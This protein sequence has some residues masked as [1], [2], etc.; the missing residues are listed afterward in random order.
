MKV[1]IL[2]GHCSAGLGDLTEGEVVEMADRIARVR[3]EA[4]WVE[5][6]AGE[7]M[8]REAPKAAAGDV[9]QEGT[10]KAAKPGRRKK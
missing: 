3:I 4:G 2:R 10:P 7:E 6:A 9:T 1:R 8:R 5:P